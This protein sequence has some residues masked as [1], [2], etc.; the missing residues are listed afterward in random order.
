MKTAFI[1]AA[2]FLV[3]NAVVIDPTTDADYITV[4]FPDDPRGENKIDG[5]NRWK[6]NQDVDN[7]FEDWYGFIYIHRLILK[8]GQKSSI[9]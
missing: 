6:L 8:N 1:A 3:S 5:E 7:P 9:S 2:L 4:D